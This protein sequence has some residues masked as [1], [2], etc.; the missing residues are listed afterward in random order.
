MVLDLDETLVCAFPHGEEPPAL[1]G[2]STFSV[3][4]GAAGRLAVFQRPGL[5]EFLLRL[6]SFADVVVFTA[7]AKGAGLSAPCMAPCGTH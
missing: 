5:N 3:S 7:S 4:A 2:R 1:R 6:S